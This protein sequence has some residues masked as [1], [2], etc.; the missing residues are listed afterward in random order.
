MARQGL[1][2]VILWNDF[3]PL[4]A[5]EIVEYAHSF[6]IE[7]IWGFALGWTEGHCESVTSLD[8]DYLT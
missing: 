2:Q 1:N 7:V 8:D 6:G 4:N 3:A 5:E